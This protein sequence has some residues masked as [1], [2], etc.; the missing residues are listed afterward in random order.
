MTSRILIAAALS[1]GLGTA[2]YGAAGDTWGERLTDMFFANPGDHTLR[3]EEEV[4]ANWQELSAEEKAQ[5]R[6]DCEANRIAIAT[7]QMSTEGSTS[8]GE[9]DSE[10]T[11][12]LCGWLD[13]MEG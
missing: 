5:V 12:K 4:R 7:D 9:V 3:S 13:G 8:R 10:T 2:A 11:G 6:A 1:F